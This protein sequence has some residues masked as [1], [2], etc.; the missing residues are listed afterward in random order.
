MQLFDGAYQNADESNGPVLSMDVA[1]TVPTST[2]T[3]INTP[4]S[5]TSTSNTTSTTS[6][7][8][9]NNHNINTSGA[10]HVRRGG[11]STL[12]LL[13]GILVSALL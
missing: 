3:Q 5:S 11:V 1:G 10:R 7:S 2:K 4:A 9:N 13:V 6:A 12:L 8:Q